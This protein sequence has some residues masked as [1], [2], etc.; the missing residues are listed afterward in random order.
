[1]LRRPSA[2]TVI[3][4]VALFVALSGTSYAVSQ[5]PKS[6]VGNAQLKANAVTGSKIKDGSIGRSDL[7]GDAIAAGPRGPRG[8]EGPAGQ[9]GAAGASGIARAYVAHAPAIVPLPSGQSPT[10][11]VGSLRLPAGSYAVDFTSH[12]FGL[13]TV[14]VWVDCSA[15]VNGT[16]FTATA[17]VI[18]RA[19][20]ASQEAVLAMT[21]VITLPSASTVTVKCGLRDATADVKM[22]T[23]VL[24]ALPVAAVEQQ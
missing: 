17:T 8:A 9:P 7:S 23:P 13:A 10:A 15:A 20:G 21:D 24:R 3:A 14:G 18:G 12:A 16:S 2:A 1:M 22:A 6:S 4:S 5:L 11:T 19:T